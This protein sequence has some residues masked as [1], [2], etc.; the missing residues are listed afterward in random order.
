MGARE[1]S[2]LAFT[3]PH[4]GTLAEE[5][6]RKA[7]QPGESSDQE[8]QRDREEAQ[9]REHGGHAEEDR[10][11]T[12]ELVWVKITRVSPNLRAREEG[13]ARKRP[14]HSSTQL[15]LTTLSVPKEVSHRFIVAW[16]FVCSI[17]TTLNRISCVSRRL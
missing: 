3:Q 4:G 2:H 13:Q 1:E 6:C 5:A 16:C 7:Q 12:K 17:V 11:G 15:G 10:G 9:G 14:T 8:D